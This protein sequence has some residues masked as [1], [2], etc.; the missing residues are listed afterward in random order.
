MLSIV[1]TLKEATPERHKLAV[2]GLH[3]GSLTVT[4]TRQTDAEIC[5]LVKN[6]DG[7]EYG[8]T[9]TEHGA[10][11]SC[12]D[13]LYRGGVCKHSIAACVFYLQQPQTTEDHLM[14][15]DGQILCGATQPRRF[16]QNWTMNALNWHDLVCQS[17]VQVW[18][19]PAATGEEC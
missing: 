18:T 8:G 16:W 9:L 14:W 11:C 6:G 4:L 13:A 1:S 17:C 2:Q 10:F 19:H 12:P 5:A 15:N 3:D 7:R